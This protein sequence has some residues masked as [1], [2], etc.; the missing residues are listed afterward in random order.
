MAYIKEYWIDKKQ[1]AFI[2]RQH[3]DQMQEKYA[4][5]IE[6]AVQHTKIYEGEADVKE[7]ERKTLQCSVEDLDSVRAVMKYGGSR[8]AVLNFASYKNPGGMFING[9]IAQEECL[10][11]ALY[12]YNVLRQFQHIY[13]DQNKTRLNKTLYTNKA[14]YTPDVMFFDGEKKVQCDVITCAAPNISAG[15]KYQNVPD[16]V[17][18]EALRSRIQF[19]LD[20]A[21]DNQVDTLILGAF[22]C[23]VFGQD[24]AEVARIFKEYL[25]TTHSCFDRVVFAVPD[26]TNSNYKAFCQTFKKIEI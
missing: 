10:C 3:T 17:N 20:I 19:V 4:E 12:L 16:S 9:S 25:T 22:G 18:T 26:G 5:Q 11:H 7:T 8:C 13:Y 24:A 2:A 6:Q 1:R 23:G 21:K 14:L 15:R